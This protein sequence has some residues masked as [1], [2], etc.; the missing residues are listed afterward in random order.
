MKIE[1]SSLST[2]KGSSDWFTGNVYVDSIAMDGSG[3]SSGIVHFTPGARTA[4]HTHALG[5]TIHILEG[6]GRVQRQGGEIEEVRAGDTVFFEPDENHWHGA[7]P[8][9]FI[10]HVAIVR[11]PASGAGTTWGDLVTDGEYT[12]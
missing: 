3:L 5:Q 7:A 6:V 11:N 2:T 10:A 1:R 9:R 4:W 12:P 8:D